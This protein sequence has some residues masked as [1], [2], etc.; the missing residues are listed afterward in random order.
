[1]ALSVS[2]IR[3][4]RNKM[5]GASTPTTETF[6]LLRSTADVT[7]LHNTVALQGGVGSYSLHQQPTPLD[8][9]CRGLNIIPIAPWQD[10]AWSHIWGE[11]GVGIQHT[12][13]AHPGPVVVPLTL[14][15]DRS[16]KNMERRGGSNLSTHQDR[17]GYNIACLT[18]SYFLLSMHVSLLNF[19]MFFFLKTR[20]RTIT[21][22]L[23]NKQRF[24]LSMWI[25]KYVLSR[26]HSNPSVRKSAKASFLSLNT[27]M[28]RKT[29]KAIFCFVYQCF[30]F[31]FLFS[32]MCCGFLA[33]NN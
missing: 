17:M 12:A 1:M 19:A 27:P 28:Q 10:T 22:S 29:S 32:L 3:L 11:G 24:Y 14:H 16:E 5:K 26:L 33:S 13:H 18:C 20:F 15:R 9:S 7:I 8:P 6:F 31:C 30:L 21:P 23:G 2:R 4:N 25:K